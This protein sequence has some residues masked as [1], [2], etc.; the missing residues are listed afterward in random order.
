MGI[1]AA[2]I[3]RSELG[4]L[5]GQ[6]RC[7]SVLCILLEV[8]VGAGGALQNKGMSDSSNEAFIS[9]QPKPEEMLTS[10]GGSQVAQ[11][12]GRTEG[13]RWTTHLRIE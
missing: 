12:L 1:A 9:W 10:Q 6:R 7:R 4:A 5:W 8:G 11:E 13:G 3:D 2:R